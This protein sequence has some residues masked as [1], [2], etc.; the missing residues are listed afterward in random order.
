MGL[1]L[2]LGRVQVI[3]VDVADGDDLGVGVAKDLIEVPARSVV[4]AADVSVDDA[5]AR[6]RGAVEPQGGRRQDIR[7]G[8]GARGRSRGLF[9]N[10]RRERLCRFD[11]MIFS[12]NGSNCPIVPFS[13]PHFN[14]TA[15]ARWRTAKSTQSVVPSSGESLGR[16]RYRR[17]M[18]FFAA[19]RMT[20]LDNGL[21][22][23]HHSM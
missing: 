8:H 3:L 15:F 2:R 19:L 10:A 20:A 4:P 7:R 14:T 6:G 11:M 21:H 12:K 16:D 1:D 17:P 9:K 22:R 13:E 5:V 23:A 18:R